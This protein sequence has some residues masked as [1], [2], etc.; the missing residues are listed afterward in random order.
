MILA[1]AHPNEFSL[2]L[3]SMFL[4][5][6]NAALEV[7]LHQPFLTRFE[8]I[9]QPASLD[10]DSLIVRQTDMVAAPMGEHLMMMSVEQGCYYDLNP[11]ARFIW[12]VLETPR[13]IRDLCLLVSA[14]FEVSDVVCQNT[15]LNFANHLLLENVVSVIK[16]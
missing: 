16:E 4:G 15:V 10:L 7:S 9:M 12:Q 5:A 13:R 3:T 11:T 6:D 1:N 8:S 14:E 2:L